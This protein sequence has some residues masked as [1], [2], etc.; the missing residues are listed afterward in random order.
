MNSRPPQRSRRS[1]TRPRLGLSPATWR[2]RWWD[3][4]VRADSPWLC[5]QAYGCRC[6]C[7]DCA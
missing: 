7:E 2:P 3:Q 4:P 1:S 5:G 6:F